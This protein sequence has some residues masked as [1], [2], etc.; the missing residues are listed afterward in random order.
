VSLVAI[1]AM[2]AASI[3]LSVLSA[4]LAAADPG[5]IANPTPNTVTTDA[6]PTVQIDGVAWAQKIVGNT[7]YVGGQ[8]A[9][10]RPAGAAPGT[11]QTT[12][13]NLLAYDLTTGALITSFAP[14]LNAQV[15]AL[16]VS[17]DGSRIYVGGSFT[18]ANGITRSRLAAYSTATGALITSFATPS[19]N[20]S[21]NAIVATNTAV[22]VGGIFNLAGGQTRQ[23]LAAFSPTNGALLAWNPGADATV[24]T[25]VMSPDGKL[26]VGGAFQNVNS[27]PAYGLAAVD[28]GSG[29]LLQWNATNL[30]RNAGAN[31]A[32]LSL[33]TDGKAVYGTGYHFGAGGNLEGTFSAD[34]VSGDINWVED[35]H[36]DTYDH[37]VGG[38]IVYTVSHAHYCGNIG[39]FPQSDPWATNMRRALAFTDT[40]TGTAGHDPYGYYDFYGTPSPSMIN[41]FPVLEAGT[42]TGKTQAAWTVTGNGQYVVMGGEFPR[43]NGKGQ[44]GLVRFAVKPIAPA[45]EGPE[46]SGSRFNPSVISLPGGARVAWQA[47]SDKDNHTLTYRL[48]RDGVPIYQADA[49]S[50]FWN[51]PT[52]GFIDRTVVPGTTYKYRLSATDADGNAVQSDIVNFT[53]PA[54]S[55]TNAYAQRVTA[56]GAAP[57]W[58][59]NETSGTT[60]FDNAGFNDADSGS[61]ITRGVTPGA[62]S[63]D[64]A[65]AFDG[66]TSAST[67]TA[68]DG[69]NTFTSQVWI[70]TTTTSGGKILGFGG[71]STGN[72]SSY[73]RHIYM[74]D[75]GRIWF[76]VYPN[77]VATV[78]SNTSYNDGLWHQITASLGPD[79]MKL[80]VDDKLVSQR[81]DVTWGQ[82]FQGYWRVGGDNIGGWP[83]QPS[84]NTFAGA[85]DEVAIYPTVLSRQTI[86]AQWVASGRTSTIPTAPADAYGAAVYNDNPLLYWRLGES[87]G[88]TA[89]DSGPNGD[90]AGIY[91]N[92]VT[93]GAP[94]GIRGTTNT[95]ASFDGSDDFVASSNSY[96]N[97]MNYSVEAWFKTTTTNGGKIIGFGCSQSGTSGCYDRHVYMN[98]DGK[99]TF[100]VWTG[101]TNTITT[102]KALNDGQWHHVVATQSST[103]GMKMY[104]DGALAGTNGQTSAQDYSGYWR[105]GGDNHWGCCSPFV[106][107][108][109]DDAAVYN[110]VLSPAQVATHFS[111]G[112][113]VVPPNQAP[114]AAFTS[115]AANLVAS[116]DGSGSSDPD[117]TIV[118]QAWDFGD[119]Q[120][121]TGATPSHTYAQAGTFTVSLTVTD[122]GGQTNVVSHPVT[123]VAPPANVPPV[124]AFSSTTAALTATFDGSGSSDSDGTVNGFA[125]NFGDGPTGTGAT[126]T[127]TYAT[128]GTY[129]VSLTVTD[130]AGGTNTVSHQVTVTAPPVNTPPVAS[131]TVVTSELTANFDGSGS[132]DADGSITGYAW[133]FGDSTTGSGASPQHLYTAAG[134][135]S[136]SLTVTDNKGA[137]N[138]TTQSVQVTAPPPNVPPTA[139]FQTTVD[140]ATVNVESTST[141][142]DGL[143]VGYLWEFGDGA[144][145]TDSAAVHTYQAG[146]TY[147]VKL[148]V[149][150]DDGDSTSVTKP[151]TVTTPPPANVPPTAAF[152]ATPNGLQAAVN[153]SSSTDTDG[154]IAAYSWDFGDGST[155]LVTTATAN[156]TYLAAGTY[157]VTLTVTDNQ[158][159]TG[160]ATHP[161][162]VTA[163]APTALVSDAFG[164]TVASGFGTADTGGAWTI[165]G[166]AS[167]FSVN[168]GTGKIKMAAAGSG[169]SA[170]LGAPGSADVDLTVDV[171]LDKAATGGGTYLSSAL[172]KVGNSEYRTTTKFLAGGS[173]QMQLVKI[174]NGT[175][176]TLRTV[177]VPGLTYTAGDVVTVRFQVSGTTSVALNAKAWKA[178][179]SEPS[180]W[181]ASAT[182]TSATLSTTG[183]VALYPY[184]S[185]T[186]TLGAVV[187]SYDNLKV[188]ALTP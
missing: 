18:T 176:T 144:T 37:Y 72:S 112:N 136:V 148:T 71:S 145:S 66:A 82:A 163:P 184:L 143:I 141:D 11:A 99:V 42:Y 89:A 110:G 177:T 135:Y 4:P 117:G 86:D 187:A 153:G 61:G 124:A 12:R 83:N 119:G 127:H 138:T 128:G 57:Y 139:A 14:N 32:I 122:N 116:F 121:G 146:G 158:G 63:G 147:S 93:L 84:S 27:A 60:L 24:N 106:S 105:V 100:G 73:D 115:S 3:S 152:T 23:R 162:T 154:T 15:K 45:K 20:A 21:V 88:T 133:N 183:G 168:A 46:Y 74:D 69:P 103:D 179:T 175:S 55:S 79:G 70:K 38:G 96:S 33:S 140:G 6:L 76:G 17:P 54:D 29:A 68:I 52:M 5:P 174:V 81:G 8:F 39:G 167:N 132:T 26:I 28:A 160:T 107:A 180:A 44:Q 161:V 7:V 78:N 182:D 114:V 47:N 2:V 9:N 77:G 75:A 169:P 40:A 67:R 64:T 130:N 36:G 109:I 157:S 118:G 85:I 172:R 129:T 65:T 123:V 149:T 142:T 137:T 13:N 56:D 98:N 173:V 22:Y 49:D 170:T 59:M 30:I 35:C 16:A 58:P 155:D 53:A 186:S 51:R 108:T 104:I 111:L 91:Q 25:M 34:P 92:G 125:W 10:A 159:A 87:S 156:H 171:A 102:D 80:Y 150:D 31:S 50:T 41:W 19:I 188:V 165:T 126:P 101:F 120:T 95:A 178:G 185:G 134:T 151:V 164:R 181:Q 1:V 90:Q 97:P 43:V 113:T 48:T 94:S 166:G 62:I 131:F